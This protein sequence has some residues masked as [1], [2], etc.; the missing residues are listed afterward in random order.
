MIFKRVRICGKKIIC[1][2]E[3]FDRHD[4]FVNNEDGGYRRIINFLKIS[5]FQEEK[6]IEISKINTDI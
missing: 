3:S 2:F 5:Y 1:D 6:I 4:K